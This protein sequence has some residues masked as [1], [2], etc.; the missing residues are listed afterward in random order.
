MQVVGIAVYA[1]PLIMLATQTVL[2]D[3]DGPLAALS[4]TGFY[5]ILGQSDL[6]RRFGHALGR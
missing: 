4:T 5:A 6:F 2:Q 1:E 3:F